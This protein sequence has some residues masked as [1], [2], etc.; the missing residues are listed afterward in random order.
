MPAPRSSRSASRSGGTRNPRQ[1]SA[2]K[3]SNQSRSRSTK[4]AASSKR[5]SSSQAAAPRTS[6]TGAGDGMAT[7][8]EQLVNRIIRP[9]GLVMLTR[10]RIQETLDDAA[11]R[12]RMTRSDAN[13][14]VA[15]LVHRGREQTD[16]LLAD[17]E[18]L[19]GRGRSQLDSARRRARRS[20]PVD[21]LVRA[22]DRAR[23]SVGVG[24]AFPISGYDELTASQ[25]SARLDALSPAD[26]RRVR[27]YEQ[28]HA[29]RKSVLEAIE[30][31]LG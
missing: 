9:L 4:A 3:R 6:A 18:Q 23:R 2:G 15:E 31:T 20:E 22:A 21:Q 10:E 30:R 14:L 26:L 19:L 29:N 12:G 8:V 25:V 11:E 28:R 17:F 1:G 24:P 5:A 7:L 27:D 16:D 13:A